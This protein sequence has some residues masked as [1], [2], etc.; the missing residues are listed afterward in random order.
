MQFTRF[1][2]FTLTCFARGGAVKQPNF[3]R[4]RSVEK[5]KG[6]S[7]ESREWC[8]RRRGQYTC[9]WWTGRPKDF[10]DAACGAW[11]DCTFSVVAAGKNREERRMPN[12]SKA[13]K[14]AQV[15]ANVAGTGKSSH[16]PAS[17]RWRS[18]KRPALLNLIGYAIAE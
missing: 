13:D 5:S 18:R 6:K 3:P 11:N 8:E 14:A 9:C 12:L 4:E 16:W 17:A 2:R 10:F 7:R 1:T 15:S